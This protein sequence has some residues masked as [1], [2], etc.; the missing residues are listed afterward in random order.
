M[1]DDAVAAPRAAGHRTPH[2]VRHW[3]VMLYEVEVGG[4]E[5]LKRMAEVADDGH[6][7]QEDFRQSHRRTDVQVDAPADQLFDQR[8]EEEKVAVSRGADSRAVRMRMNVDDV[9]SD[10]DVYRDG[11]FQK[12]G[13]MQDREIGVLRVRLDQGAAYRLAYAAIFGGPASDRLVDQ[14]PGFFGHPERAAPQSR[15]DVFRS[16]SRDGDLE[17]VNHARAVHGDGRNKAAPRQVDQDRRQAGF[18]DVAADAPDDRPIFGFGL[19]DCAGDRTERVGGEDVRQGIEQR[20]RVARL[21]VGQ[22]FGEIARR[23][24]ARTRG[25]RIGHDARQIN[26]LLPVD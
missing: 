6:G 13:R 4:G 9:C 2:D 16:P 26:R 8:C 19:D 17:I 20:G 15:V 11:D 12:V 22:G 14:T 24:F 3:A 21:V 5:I 1:A 25:E 10:R 7:F 18:D 23:D